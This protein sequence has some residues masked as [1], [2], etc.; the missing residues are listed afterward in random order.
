MMGSSNSEKLQNFPP[1]FIEN[2]AAA[3]AVVLKLI[4]WP[5]TSLCLNMEKGE[6]GLHDKPIF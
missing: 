2:S 6:F 4:L 1:H 5:L 3:T